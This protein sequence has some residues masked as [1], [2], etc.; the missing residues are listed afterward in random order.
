LKQ[1]YPGGT[2]DDWQE[3]ARESSSCYCK[4]P[5]SNTPEGIGAV[6]IIIQGETT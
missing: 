1:L 2:P 4:G 6:N 5:N 3:L